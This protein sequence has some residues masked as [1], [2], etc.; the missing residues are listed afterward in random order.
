MSGERS[1]SPAEVSRDNVEPWKTA[2]IAVHVGPLHQVHAR[3]RTLFVLLT[4]LSALL[5]LTVLSRLLV[6]DTMQPI[7]L[8]W[9]S[10][11]ALACIVLTFSEI[12]C[13][14]YIRGSA[15]PQMASLV[16]LDEQ[17]GLYNR[18]YLSD[19]IDEEVHRCR[20]RHRRFALA[21]FDLDGFKGVNDQWGHDAGDAVLRQCARVL[22]RSM[23]REDILGRIGG[24]EFLAL[25][26]DTGPSEAANS[27]I[28]AH[29]IFAERTF[30]TPSG[31]TAGPLGLSVGLACF[32]DDGGDRETI[33]AAAD[34]RM[35]EHKASRKK[36]P[37]MAAG[38]PR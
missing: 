38:S 3:V 29:G 9:M 33:W 18:R 25:L 12:G 17:T 37:G 5:L 7:D 16:L 10:C 19:R 14:R 6:Q 2:E 1:E 4:A 8:A 24:D 21:Y 30:Q 28:R 27:I 32:P 36:G 13:L 15:R 23:R 31:E 11:F 35:Y 26:P 22:R 34:R 20:R